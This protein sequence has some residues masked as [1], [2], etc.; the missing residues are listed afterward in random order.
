MLPPEV[1]RL[2]D[3]GLALIPL[4][5]DGGKQPHFQYVP[6][7][8]YYQT[9]HPLPEELELW[10]GVD[11]PRVNLGVVCGKLSNLI[12]LDLDDDDTYE[13]VLEYVPWVPDETMVVRTG[14]GWHIY[15]RPTPE[16]V[17]T[18]WPSTTS[19]TLNEKRHHFKAEPSYV[20]APPSIHENGNQYHW[21]NECDP[22]VLDPSVL[23]K[24][25]MAAGAVPS[26][27]GDG[28]R[29]DKPRD[30]VSTYLSEP[31]PEGMRNER[32]AQIAGWF[33]SVIKYKEDVVIALMR[34]W[35]QV[36][37]RPPMDD[38]ELV[39]LVEHKFRYYPAE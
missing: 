28:P 22:L 30:W 20:Q 5:T 1:E 21:I 32:A 25:V 9:R 26:G 13:Q 29:E 8:K 11:R 39:S 19:F 36:W 18:T 33:R 14:R 4:S 10:F 17:A 16:S 6:S 2:R 3:L 12:V 37:C 23:V 7:W 15:F 34:N 31:C 35:S 24:A 27:G 38:A